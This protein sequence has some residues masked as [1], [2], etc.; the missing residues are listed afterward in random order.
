[1]EIIYNA[2]RHTHTLTHISTRMPDYII[3]IWRL[4][5]H[6]EGESE[7]LMWFTW[8]VS[9]VC[10]SASQ[11][12]FNVF[13]YYYTKR[14]MLRYGRGRVLSNNH[15]IDMCW[16]SFESRWGERIHMHAQS[17]AVNGW[18]MIMIVIM[19]MCDGFMVHLTNPRAQLVFGI[20]HTTWNR[21]TWPEHLQFKHSK[22][23]C[24]V[25]NRIC[26]AYL[27]SQ[28]W[29]HYTLFFRYTV[30]RC[31]SV[32]TFQNVSISKTLSFVSKTNVEIWLHLCNFVM[33]RVTYFQLFRAFFWKYFLKQIA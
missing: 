21:C 33:S 29:S 30:H 5:K 7:V 10:E 24:S 22:A 32:Q 27:Y 2:N 31:K 1:M 25:Q 17:S 18:F 12:G 4:H 20:F 8:C 26:V 3:S 16:C 9:L 28:M 13:V 23:S 6:T 11:G 19:I 14:Y 15:I